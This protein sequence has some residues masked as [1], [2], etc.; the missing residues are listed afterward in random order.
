[1]ATF[2]HNFKGFARRLG[3][4]RGREA[5]DGKQQEACAKFTEHLH[6]LFPSRILKDDIVLL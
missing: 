5:G 4:W 3:S 6:N 1:M 2:F